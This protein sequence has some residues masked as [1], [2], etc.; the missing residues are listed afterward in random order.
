MGLLGARTH[1]GFP[2]ILVVQ[3]WRSFKEL[4]TYA[5]NK[6]A[7]HLPAWRDFNRRISSN[8]DVGIWHETY[9]IPAGHYEAVYNHMPVYGLGQ[10]FPLEPASGHRA[11]AVARMH[12]EQRKA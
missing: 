12:A 5:G 9:R 4:V 7:T 10:I 3:Y 8:G 11:S 2:N 6:N 1:F